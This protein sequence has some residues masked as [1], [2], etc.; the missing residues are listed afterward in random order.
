[1]GSNLIGLVGIAVLLGIAY[2]L[3]TNRKAINLR[4]VGAAFALQVFIAVMV[5]YTDGGSVVLESLAN[6]VNA[7]IGYSR[8]G[9]NMIFGSLASQELLQLPEDVQTFKSDGRWLGEGEGNYVVVF[10]VHVLPV[11]IFFS[12][13][14]SVMYHLRI[15]QWVGN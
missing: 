12:A 9:I 3:S 14:M 2:A 8:E 13:L 11:I 1:M 15:M 5:L 10:A 4:V 7:V 6:G